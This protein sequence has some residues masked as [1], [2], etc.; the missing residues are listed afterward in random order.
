MKR[1]M[2]F[3]NF[4]GFLNEIKF[5]NHWKERSA[6]PKE[7]EA[8][9]SR[10][11]EYSERS[12]SG[13]TLEGMIDNK[14]DKVE[15]E[16]FLNETYLDTEKLKS[17]IVDALR[18]LTRSETLEK[19][20]DNTPLRYQLLYLGKI[21]VYNG[22]KK[23][24]P[25]LKTRKEEKGISYEPSDG[26]WGISDKN[27][28]I[29][30][31][32]FP[33]TKKG[34]EMFYEQAKRVS[35]MRDLDFLNNTNFFSPY[36]QDFELIIDA[37]DPNAISRKKKLVKQTSGE[38]VKYGPEEQ[39]NYTYTTSAEPQRKTFSVGDKIGA[40]VKYVS[41]T[42]TTPGT[43]LEIMN[44]KE[45]EDAQKAK[46]LE[47]VKEIK[48]RFVPDLEKDRKYTS[49]GKVL[50]IP[51]TLTEGSF[52]EIEGTRYK[53][54]GASGNK[55]LVTSEPSIIQKGSVQTWVEETK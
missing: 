21:G 11:V 45:I 3:E 33:S 22:K 19:W 34:A 37:T 5:T 43:I 54:L 39:K 38:E 47:K 51:V 31:M 9:E 44:I 15:I 14:G 55:P 50:A 17:E 13:W 30:F 28:G 7:K 18:I 12:K 52:V 32:Y 26:V 25:L 48:V 24:F 41:Q 46:N 4:S 2:L 29:T 42:E 40:I 20:S 36:G 35:G 1:L 49:D 23:S 10:I 53:I 16:K 6:L 27:E 8:A